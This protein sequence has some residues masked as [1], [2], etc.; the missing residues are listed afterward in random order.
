M[1]D[2]SGNGMSL[3]MGAMTV[4]LGGRSPLLGDPKGYINISFTLSSKGALPGGTTQE[5]IRSV[6]R[7]LF[8]Y[9]SKSPVIE[10]P[11]QV[12]Q[13]KGLPV[14]RA[15]LKEGSGAGHLSP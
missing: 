3:S 9:L 10:F 12:P 2:V 14:P 6:S 11:L 8:Y 15:F 13:W 5:E 4:E 7:A 1:K